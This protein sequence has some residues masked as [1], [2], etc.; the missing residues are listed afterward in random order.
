[1]VLF[2]RRWAKV[3]SL[4]PARTPMQCRERWCNVLDTS[5]YKGAWSAQEDHRLLALCSRYRGNG[6]HTLIRTYI[7]V[8][9]THTHTR[10]STTALKHTLTLT[11]SHPP[12]PPRQAY[13]LVTCGSRTGPP[14]RLNVRQAMET[15]FVTRCHRSAVCQPH[16]GQGGTPQASPRRRHGNHT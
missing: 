5:L 3:A 12:P 2:G 13:P 8:I 7:P 9:H 16:L 14:D 11:P 15:P 4:V 10:I 6:T 1:M